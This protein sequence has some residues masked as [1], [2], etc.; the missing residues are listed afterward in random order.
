MEIAVVAEAKQVKL[1]ALALHHSHVGD[2]T[3]ADFRKIGLPGDGA[4]TGELGAVELHPIVVVL[5]LVDEG[6]QHLGRIIHPV[7]SFLSER[8]QSLFFSCL[9]II[10]L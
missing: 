7:F 10:K 1:Q 4:E 2:V 5:M 9:H 3:D 6:L 8:L